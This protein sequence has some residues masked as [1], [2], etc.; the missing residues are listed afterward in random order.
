MRTNAHKHKGADIS[1]AKL[2]DAGLILSDT[3]RVYM[4]EMGVVN[5]LKAIGYTSEDIPALVQGT[6]P[7]V[8]TTPTPTHPHTPPT[9]TQRFRV[10][11]ISL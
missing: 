3:L 7:Q 8:G 11:P 1:N 4:Q 6:L 10:K 2:E 5:G 9:H